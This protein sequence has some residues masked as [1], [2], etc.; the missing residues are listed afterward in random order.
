MIAALERQAGG[1]ADLHRHFRRHRKAV[2]LAANAVRPEITSCHGFPLFKPIRAILATERAGRRITFG[3]S[4]LRVL[5]ERCCRNPGSTL[6]TWKVA[7]PC[8]PP[9]AKTPRT[10]SAALKRQQP[11]E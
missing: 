2:R 1:H 8:C 3:D 9:H 6:S 7:N 5:A 10:N 4:I 11:S